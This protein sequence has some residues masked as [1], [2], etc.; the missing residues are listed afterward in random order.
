MDWVRGSTIGRGSSSAVHLAFHRRSYPAPTIHAIKSAPLSYASLLQREEA[1]L[2]EL[3]GC[4]QI[5]S[6]FGHD[7]TTD[8]AGGGIDRLYNIFLE[9][10]AI[11]H[12]FMLFGLEF[13]H[14]FDVLILHF[15]LFVH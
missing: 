13:L 15:L 1:I 14:S 6:C 10:A 5:I 7:I 11:D 2:T 8:T 3:H 4:P 12:V 9:Y